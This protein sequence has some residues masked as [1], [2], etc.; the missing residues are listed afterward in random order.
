LCRSR[1]REAK[2]ALKHGEL[3]VMVERELLAGRR[4]AREPVGMLA[5]MRTKTTSGAS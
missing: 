3:E 2:A 1:L 5:A 4:T